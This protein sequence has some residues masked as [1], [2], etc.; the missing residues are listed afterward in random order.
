MSHKDKKGKQSTRNPE[1]EV[2]DKSSRII[3]RHPSRLLG[4]ANRPPATPDAEKVRSNTRPTSGTQETQEGAGRGV[5]TPTNRP[6]RSKT[7]ATPDAERV[8]PH[9]R[10][11]SGT[12]ET[13]EGAGRGVVTP[14]NCPVRSKTPATPDAERV[15]PNVR[16]TSGTQETQESAGRGVATPTNRPVRSKTPATPDAERVRGRNISSSSLSSRLRIDNIKELQA[17]KPNIRLPSNLFNIF[18]KTDVAPPAEDLP[19][20]LFF[21]RIMNERCQSSY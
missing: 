15:R 2:Q 5:V 18:E 17:R 20:G 13:Q 4:A 3:K 9:V 16:P 12:Q 8:R 1:D 19:T 6:V 7:P 10:P 14:T 11:T 21:G